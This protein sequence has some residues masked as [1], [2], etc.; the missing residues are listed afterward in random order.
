MTFNVRTAG[1]VGR[2]DGRHGWAY[3]RAAVLDII[4][5]FSPDVVG[6]Q[7][8]MPDQEA[9]L[10]AGLE[11]Y[12]GWSRPR[13][14]DWPDEA[15]EAKWIGYRQDRFARQAAGTFELSATPD[16]FGGPAWDSKH[17]RWVEWVHLVDRVT[18]QPLFVFN[19]H[20]DNA[21][22]EARLQSAALLR[23]RVATIADD[24]PAVV[25]GDFNCDADDAEPHRVLTAPAAAAGLRDAWTTYHPDAPARPTH[26]G[27]GLRQ[28]QP[29]RIDWVLYTRHLRPVS[30]EVP[31]V[32]FTHDDG[33][34]GYP[35]DHEPVQVIFDFV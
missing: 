9:D 22:S 5:A 4:E 35:S 10:R 17:Y 13:Q 7:E 15:Q 24:A 19:T 28:E 30:A 3:R 8:V 6:L 34:T 23:E 2:E 11:G 1:A 21:G 12:D 14:E 33:T 32:R 20:F 16:A 18:G 26:N 29:G 31:V 25:V 27:F